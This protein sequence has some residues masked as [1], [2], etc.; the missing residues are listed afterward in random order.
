MNVFSIK[1]VVTGQAKVPF[2]STFYLH[3]MYSSYM[4]I[5]LAFRRIDM[6]S[7]IKVLHCCKRATGTE[8]F[9]DAFKGIQQELTH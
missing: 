8:Y 7:F 2:L 5:L 6:V 3:P 4:Y 9:S 1:L